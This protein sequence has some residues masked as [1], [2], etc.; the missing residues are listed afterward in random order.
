MMVIH[1]IKSEKFWVKFLF[2]ITESFFNNL[3]YFY[4]YY[5]IYVNNVN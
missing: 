4:V 1:V 5:V 2:N 3:R